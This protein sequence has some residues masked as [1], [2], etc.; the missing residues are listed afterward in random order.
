MRRRKLD[1]LV[2]NEYPS[3]TES[4]KD[5]LQEVVFYYYYD[6]NDMDFELAIAEIQQD[7]YFL[8]QSEEYER[9]QMLKDI[10]QRFE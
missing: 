1:Q 7:L 6:R 4:E 2:Y 10:L 9:C 5:Q 3:A 8:E